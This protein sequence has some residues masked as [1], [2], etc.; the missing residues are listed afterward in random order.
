MEHSCS[1][2]E[3]WQ[4]EDET[5][6]LCAYGNC[7]INKRIRHRDDCCEEFEAYHSIGD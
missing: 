3:H 1:E 7:R 4:P 6:A 5:K 2:C